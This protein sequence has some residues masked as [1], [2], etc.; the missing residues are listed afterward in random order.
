MGHIDISQQSPLFCQRAL[1]LIS[2]YQYYAELKEL[3]KHIYRIHLSKNIVPIERVICNMVDEILFPLNKDEWGQVALQ[4]DLGTTKLQI[5]TSRIYPA[6]S[7]EAL[8]ILFRLLDVEKIIFLFEC[9]LLEKKVFF[10]SKHRDIVTMSADA[11]TQL[12]FPFQYNH[13]L[14][15]ILPDNYKGYLEVTGNNFPP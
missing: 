11:L 13:V 8:R 10:I 5:P 12:L 15:P 3:L 4:Y 1:C 2:K 14:I 6:F 7:T 9:L